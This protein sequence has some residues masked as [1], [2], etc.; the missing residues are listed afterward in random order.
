MGTPLGRGRILPNRAR[1]ERVE[2]RVVCG[3][4]L[5]Q[6]QRTTNHATPP[7]STLAY[8]FASTE[9]SRTSP[10]LA[11]SS[12]S[13]PRCLRTSGDLYIS[14]LMCRIYRPVV[15]ARD[16]LARRSHWKHYFLHIVNIR[17]YVSVKFRHQT[18]YT[19]C[20]ASCL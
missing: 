11:R 6:I 10:T 3:R 14:R 15:N 20:A 9:A 7:S 4:S 13:C 5:G 17:A 16:E 19:N 8:T 12:S 18:A 1:N 2:Y